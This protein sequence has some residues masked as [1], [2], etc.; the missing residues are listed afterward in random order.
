MEELFTGAAASTD[1][2]WMLIFASEKLD[3]EHHE[4]LARR[5]HETTT[6]DNIWFAL[7]AELAKDFVKSGRQ[8]D[9]MSYQ[10]L[11]QEISDQR[12]F[13]RRFKP[14]RR[15][16]GDVDMDITLLHPSCP[17]A[18]RLAAETVPQLKDVTLTIVPIPPQCTPPSAALCPVQLAFASA[19]TLSVSARHYARTEL[20]AHK[21][22]FKVPFMLSVRAAIGGWNGVNM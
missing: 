22:Q 4:K 2:L 15:G 10:E 17:E 20:Q 16:G 11:R 5:V 9:K 12:E 13:E 18:D 14:K 19:V 8:H 3:D 1:S 7:T 6:S 21:A